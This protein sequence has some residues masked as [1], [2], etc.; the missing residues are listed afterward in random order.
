V[1]IYRGGGMD[2]VWRNFA[3]VAGIGLA[4]FTYSVVLFRKS[5]AATK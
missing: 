4:F 1:I 3:M 2:A 5:I